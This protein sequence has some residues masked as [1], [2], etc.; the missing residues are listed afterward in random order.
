MIK[1]DQENQELKVKMEQKCL[2]IE[3]L[4]KII[5]HYK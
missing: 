3:K 5:N 2:E 1:N 4:R